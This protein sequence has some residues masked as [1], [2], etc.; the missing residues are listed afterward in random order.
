MKISRQ[1]IIYGALAISVLI[2]LVIAGA[3]GFAAYRFHDMR[4]DPKSWI[5]KR[6]Q[7]GERYFLRHLD[8]ADRE[9]AQ[10]I[11]RQH[12]PAI[13]EGFENLRAARRDFGQSLRKNPPDPQEIVPI[14]D[15]SQQ[16]GAT[17]NREF[18]G[19]LRDIATKLS[20]EARQSL[21]AQLMRRHGHRP[22]HHEDDD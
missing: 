1:K 21:S 16:A 10:E 15:R 17:I 6:L 18:H 3:A 4:D 5:E 14:L 2:N 22:P 12:K 7:R 8:E 13:R 19:L 11:F 9:M 20:P